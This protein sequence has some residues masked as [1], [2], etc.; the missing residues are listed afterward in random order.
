MGKGGGEERRAA[1]D[2]PPSTWQKWHE[3]TR[4]VGP[5]VLPPL[6]TK[7]ARLLDISHFSVAITSVVAPHATVEGG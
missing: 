5:E 3:M 2:A 1:H 6:S 7:G 4:M